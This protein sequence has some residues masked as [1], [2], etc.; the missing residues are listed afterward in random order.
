MIGN[1][2]DNRFKIIKNFK[3]NG[4]MGYIYIVED[5]KKEFNF[6]II[7]KISQP[8]YVDRFKKEIKIMTRLLE[9]PNVAKILY[10]NL[11]GHVPYYIMKFYEKGNLQDFYT[12][13][14]VKNNF[15]L[16]Q[17]IFLEMIDCIRVLHSQNKFH[18]DI[19]PDNFLLD[20]NLNILVSDFGLSV[21]LDSSSTRITST[22]TYGGSQGYLPPEFSEKARLF[23][24]IKPQSDIYM[25]GK[26]FYALLTGLNP[27]HIDKNKIDNFIYPIIYKACKIDINERY[28]N[29]EELKE[30][31]IKIFRYKLT[32]A[33]PYAKVRT[34]CKKSFLNNSETMEL[35][36]LF[37]ICKIEE[38]KNI[39][40]ILPVSF[41]EQAVK[42]N[43]ID[44]QYMLDV[45]TKIVK[46]DDALNNWSIYN[47]TFMEQFRTSMKII[48]TDSNSIHHVIKAKALYLL[49]VISG[50]TS[51]WS[52]QETLK[53]IKDEKLAEELVN[54]LLNENL[55][56]NN[57]IHG[58]N[59]FD[60][61]LDSISKL[62]THQG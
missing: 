46:V 12:L 56:G 61:E 32:E 35:Y 57:C 36:K 14:K 23:K 55:E 2:I 13:T 40:K 31:L 15:K 20:D 44:L 5:L 3:H 54:L 51:E 29:L 9:S 50:Q 47:N 48:V 39:L 52:C 43:K 59:S 16:Q 6:Q 41:F 10:S 4:G 60:C 21:D 28:K 11:E 17:E 53:S 24:Y 18:R 42:N 19:K 37:L 1:V 45:Y 38:Q 26:S 33:T 30:E 7:I 25:L 8:Q 27:L 34:L 49:V 62:I 58:I 22:G